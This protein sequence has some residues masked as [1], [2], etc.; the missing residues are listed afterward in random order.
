MQRASA[1]VKEEK[2]TKM[3]KLMFALT[4][5]AALAAVADVESSNI[6]GY[7]E[8]DVTAGEFRM[9]GIPWETA[10]G[11]LNVNDIFK[12]TS[13]ATINWKGVMDGDDPL[14]YLGSAPQIQ[15]QNISGANEGAYKVYYY[16]ANALTSF[17][18]DTGDYTTQAGWCDINGNLATPELSVDYDGSLIPGVSVWFKDP[19]ASGATVNTTTAGQVIQDAVEITCPA[20]FRLRASP[21]PKVLAL[22]DPAQLVMTGIPADTSINWE[23]VMDGDDPLEYLGSAPQIQVQL[24]NGSYKVYYYTKNALTSFDENTGDYTTQAGWC[25]INGNLATPKL[26]PEYDGTVAVNAGFWV[27]GNTGSFT[28]K[29]NP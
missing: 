14:E 8:R 16:T 10:T 4:G 22:N 7:T 19:S 3:K 6:V 21:F 5:V 27:K 2:E 12:Y 23:G 28:L 9:L 25:D 17:D 1:E 24:P 29:F 11:G 20:A 26:S 13:T 18:E 15:V